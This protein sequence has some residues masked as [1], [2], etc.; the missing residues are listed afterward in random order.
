MGGINGFFT[1]EETKQIHKRGWSNADPEQY[2]GYI[3]KED[4]L[5]L[6]CRYLI[7]NMEGEKVS[8]ITYDGIGV[9]LS[10]I[11]PIEFSLLVRVDQ[12]V[13]WRRGCPVPWQETPFSQLAYIAP[14]VQ[15]EHFKPTLT[16]DSPRGSYPLEIRGAGRMTCLGN[17][18]TCA[19]AGKLAADKN[20]PLDPRKMCPF[21]KELLA[22]VPVLSKDGKTDD[23]QQK[24]AE[25]LNL[26]FDNMQIQKPSAAEAASSNQ[27]SQSSLIGI[28]FGIEIEPAPERRP[29]D[30]NG[31]RALVDDYKAVRGRSGSKDAKD[32]HPDG[33]AIT[34]KQECIDSPSPAGQPAGQPGTPSTSD[35]EASEQ[36][37]P[38]LDQEDQALDQALDQ[39]FMDVDAEPETGPKTEADAEMADA[40]T[41]QTQSQTQVYPESPE[42]VNGMRL[43]NGVPGA[44]G[45]P[46]YSPV[47]SG[48]VPGDE[49]PDSEDEQEDSSDNFDDW[50]SD[51]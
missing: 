22:A 46:V 34:V 1:D 29:P 15:N 42:Y 38:P 27:S 6:I 14:S 16:F 36:E 17:S 40:D 45:P 41:A 28:L 9:E 11:D 35:E 8:K 7:K 50:E 2:R 47:Y 48:M 23:T 4:A 31:C 51:G 12:F 44:P 5:K 43:Y 3:C 24:R 10:F 21:C 33:V 30:P 37:V 19:C 13:K 25:D 26:I 39:A 49:V 20:N 18:S 32:L